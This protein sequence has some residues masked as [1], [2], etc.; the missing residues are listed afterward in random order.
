MVQ[1]S[2]PTPRHGHGPI[3][4]PGPRGVPG[5]RPGPYIHTL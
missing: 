1:A 5:R 3:P 4:G 2:N